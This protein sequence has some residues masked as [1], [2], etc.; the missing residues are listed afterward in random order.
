MLDDAA[1]MLANFNGAKTLKTTTDSFN[2]LFA[3]QD[4]ILDNDNEMDAEAEEAAE[5]F[6]EALEA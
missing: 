1:P 2:D 3:V 5:Q 6:L 4:K